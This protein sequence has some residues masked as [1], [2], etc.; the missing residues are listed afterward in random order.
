[1]IRTR[2]G[3]HN[4]PLA[5]HNAPFREPFAERKTSPSPPM[6]NVTSSFRRLALLGLCCAATALPGHAALIIDQGY[7]LFS[8]NAFLDLDGAGPA[9]L[10]AYDGVPIG[11]FD[12]GLAGVHN[13]SPADTIVH[14]TADLNVPGTSGSIPLEIVGLQLMSTASYDPDGAGPLPTGTYFATLQRNRSLSEVGVFGAG[15]LSTGSLNVVETNPGVGGT[16]SSF[17]DVWFDLRL[18][19]FNGPI[20]APAPAPKSFTGTGGLWSHTQAPGAL[21]PAISGV[22]Y[23]LNGVDTQADFWVTAPLVHDAGDG[24]QHNIDPIPEAGT[25]LFG[26]AC[27]GAVALRRRRKVSQ[28]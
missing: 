27:I 11:S 28:G 9:P 20:V 19:G 8:S 22:D 26:M 21:L 6:P 16:F 18:G 14:R 1:M 10:Q 23:L 3:K 5:V 7:D 24:T 17:F 4:G 13:P 25:A 2:I 15:N 12:F